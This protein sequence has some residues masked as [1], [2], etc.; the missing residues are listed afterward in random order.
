MSVYVAEVKVKKVCVLLQNNLFYKG[1]T[2][3][4]QGSAIL[5]E[6]VGWKKERREG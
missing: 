3:V 5:T 6:Q 1:V 2:L 4:K